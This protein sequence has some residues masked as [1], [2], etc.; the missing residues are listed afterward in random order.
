MSTR[1]T[2]TYIN[3]CEPHN[4]SEMLSLRWRHIDVEEGKSSEGVNLRL[5][6]SLRNDEGTKEWGEKLVKFG[7]QLIDVE[8]NTPMRDDT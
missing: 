2:A 7:S 4:E 3:V 6:L 5:G 8:K 1:H